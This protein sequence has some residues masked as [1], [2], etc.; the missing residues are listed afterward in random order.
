M[1]VNSILQIYS[2]DEV[3]KQMFLTCKTLYF[4]LLLVQMKNELLI[5]SSLYLNL[6]NRFYVNS[7]TQTENIILLF[8]NFFD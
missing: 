2:N 6:K 3:E 7:I 5:D 8:V 1:I 4:S